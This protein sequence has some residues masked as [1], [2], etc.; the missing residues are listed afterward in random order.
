MGS[1]GKER[2]DQ[3]TTLINVTLNLVPISDYYYYDGGGG[4]RDTHKHRGDGQNNGNRCEIYTFFFITM[5]LGHHLPVI[6]LVSILK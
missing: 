1:L 6:H 3:N 4:E 2:T 5:E